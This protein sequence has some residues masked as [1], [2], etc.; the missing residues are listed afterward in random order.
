[1]QSQRRRNPAE[2]PHQ[3]LEGALHEV[4]NALTV[5]LGWIAEARAPG[6]SP[7]AVAGALRMV[8]DRA[9]AARDLARRAIGAAVPDVQDARVSDVLSGCVSVLAVEAHRAG[10]RVTLDQECGDA[11]I[12]FSDDVA[13]IVTNLVL[14]A[15]AHAPRG[16]E[17][18]V[19]G[20]LRDADVVVCVEDDGPG[21]EPERKETIF[22]GDTRREGGAGV[23]LRHARAIARAAGGELELARKEGGACFVLTWPRLD[24][25]KP[26]R[27]APALA[28]RILEGR[29][30]LVLED[31]ADV[32]ELLETALGARGAE[33]TVARTR[34][35]LARAL[36]TP[37]DAVLVDLSP[38]GADVEDA[39][40]ELRALAPT[41]RVVFISGSAPSLPE[42]AWPEGA[43][44]V[45]KP[46]EVGEV[47]GALVE[48]PG[49]H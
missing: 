28:L 46:F 22:D 15:L 38:L 24:A 25:P 49:A 31:D 33:V 14:N 34:E 8:E 4:S 43:R 7:E 11:R 10:A 48:A 1:V 26:A 27:S 5:L 29:R 21:V 17:V 35:E 36:G 47:V 2:D 6:A 42:G 45:R 3:D 23:G 39:L 44:L 19:R 13:Q 9:R 41:A 30:I 37:H 16:S 32:T 20:R 18:R 40:A 12:R